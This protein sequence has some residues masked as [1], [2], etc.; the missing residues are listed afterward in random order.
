M[1]KMKSS[2]EGGYIVVETI[3]AFVPFVMLVISIL[4]LVNIVAVQA[5]VHYALTQAANAMSM[6]DYALEV[7]GLADG[8]STMNDKASTVAGEARAMINDI[9]AVIDGIDSLSNISGAVDGG[10]SAINRAYGWGEDI[11]SDPKKT[12]QY[13]MNYG[14]NE[15]WD[16]LLEVIARPLVG[17]YLANGNMSGDEYLRSVGVVNKR[18]GAK[19]LDALEFYQFT[20]FGIGNSALL[21]KNGNVKLTVSYEIM[22]TFAG[23]PMPFGPTLKIRQTVV[24]KAW[25]GGSGEGY[26]G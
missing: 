14:L 2:N 25:L 5:R 4:S 21:D 7:I 16:S 17:R 20:N 26:K 11:V 23:L 15:L 3:G 6:Y 13:L 22:Y 12:L 1:K 8:V 24:T 18:N 10:K 19:G 9:N